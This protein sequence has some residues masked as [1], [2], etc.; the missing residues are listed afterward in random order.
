LE[1]QTDNQPYLEAHEEPFH[2]AE[3]RSGV[4]QSSSAPTPPP[5]LVTM[6]GAIWHG[7]TVQVE[8]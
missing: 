5:H 4:R 3:I 7:R 6:T 1:A 2:P 8:Q